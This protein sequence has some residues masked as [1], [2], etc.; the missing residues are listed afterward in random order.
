MNDINVLFQNPISF[1][2]FHT[3]HI[4]NFRNEVAIGE[5]LLD[6]TL[7]IWI[8]ISSNHQNSAK[9]SGLLI[10]RILQSLTC[11]EQPALW[12]LTSHSQ[13]VEQ[14]GETSISK[15][16][17]SSCQQNN[18]HILIKHAKKLSSKNTSITIKG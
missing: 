10:L 1:E 8:N 5:K 9:M 14:R 12:K 17:I 7:Y 11:N 2:Q 4:F 16:I 13:K 18:K 6:T 15:L 3:C